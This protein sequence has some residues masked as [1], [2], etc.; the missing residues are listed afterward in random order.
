LSYL[1]AARHVIEAGQRDA[2]LSEVALPAAYLQ[3]HALETGL[4]ALLSTAYFI[5]KYDRWHD[6]LKVDAQ[7]DPP[8]GAE[9]PAKHS[10]LFLRDRLKA[11]L[12]SGGHEPLPDEVSQL[13]EE[14]AK[15]EAG[16]PERY[17]VTRT[18]KGPLEDAF[19]DEVKLPIVEMQQAMEDVFERFFQFDPYADS[20]QKTWGG[21]LAYDAY[22]SEQIVVQNYPSATE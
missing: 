19:P 5:D 18:P 4:K 15:Q 13:C 21:R 8:A 6:L 22:A 1:L 20:D 16:A 3:R 12:D 2:R 7:A 10:H 14:V 17:R 11:A 9:V